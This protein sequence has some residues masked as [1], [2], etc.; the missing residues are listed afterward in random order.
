MCCRRDPKGFVTRKSVTE[1]FGGEVDHIGLTLE[2]AEKV[3]NRNVGAL[4][5]GLDSGAESATILLGPLSS[6][7]L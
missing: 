2:V 6:R 4:G 1:R 7:Q 3:A 5:D